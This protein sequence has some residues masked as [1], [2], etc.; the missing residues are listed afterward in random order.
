[1]AATIASRGTPSG[2]VIIALEPS[3]LDLIEKLGY[4]QPEFDEIIGVL[5]TLDPEQHQHFVLS[6]Y[7]AYD[8]PADDDF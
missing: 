4:Q 2:R 3:T 5:A 1:M 7:E 8:E 6:L